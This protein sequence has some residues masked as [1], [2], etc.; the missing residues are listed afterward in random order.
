M[1]VVAAPSLPPLP[2]DEVLPQLAAAL[3]GGGS[4]I[5]SAP[6]GSGKTTRAPLALL[7]APWLAGRKI[8]LLEPRRLA[9]RAAARFMARS[10]G[11][12]VGDTVGFRVR[13]ERQVSR[14]TRVEVLTEGILTRRLQQ[15]PDLEGVGLVIFDEFHER[16]LQA[17]LGLALCLDIRQGLR[18]ELRLLVMSATLELEPLRALLGDAALVT[19]A[20]RSYP[21]ETLYDPGPAEQPAARAVVRGVLRALREREGDLLAFLPGMGEIRAAESLLRERLEDTEILVRPLY[22]DLDSAAQDSAI[23]PDPGGRRR[24]VLATSIAESSLTIE[25]VSLVVDAG[26]SRLPRFDPNTGLTR[27]TTLRVSRAA[28]EQRRGR[29]GRLGPGVCYRLWP[30]ALTL[31]PHGGAEILQADLAPLLLELALWGVDEPSELNWLDAPPAGAVAQARELLQRLEALD[32]KGRI[33]P[34]GRRMA[35]LPLHPRLAH[36]LLRAGGSGVLSR[37]ADLAALLSERDIFRRGRDGLRSH[38]LE[39]RLAA[40]ADWRK[41]GKNT[42]YPVDATAC[43]RVDRV[44]RQLRSLAGLERERGEGEDV[45]VGALVALAY[46]ERVAQRRAASGGSY[47]LANGR[48]AKLAEEDPLAGSPYLAVAAMDAGVREGRIFLAAR[49][50]RAELEALFGERITESEQVRWDAGRRAVSARRELRLDALVLERK[51]LPRPAPE[52]LLAALLEGIRR[53]GV[54]SLPWSQSARDL[55]ARMLCLRRWEPEGGWPDLSDQV[56]LRDLERWLGPWLDGVTGIAQL[57]R[58]NLASILRQGLGWE[59]Q[60]LLDELAPERIAVP[61]GSRRALS[62]TPGEPPVLAVKLQEMFGQRDT[63]RVCRGRVPVTLHLLSPA[64][65][66]LQ[67][68]QDLAGFW[69]RTYAEVR[70]EMK[71]RYPKHYWPEDPVTAVATARV[72]PKS[73]AIRP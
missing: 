37:A 36:M 64:R 56:L 35:A 16:S 34:L 18:E 13:L 62:Y 48:G 52:R 26:W 11:E 17:D 9:A 14:R 69:D 72:R 39:Q 2:V 63:P 45:S 67:I 55:Q 65:R 68:T 22:G 3:A 19:A 70:K 31:N 46:P 58:L 25:G 29:A 40:L 61:S 33:T 8:L 66:P 47:L 4:A 10:L 41:P 60:R 15:D 21:V 71:G 6:P 24:V 43:R 20:G 73:Q 28:A 30:E 50:D 23:R 49:L 57:G 59:R 27:L 44:S 32:P 1:S 42:A 54:G 5:L 53:E 51:P 38:D 12:A 7:N